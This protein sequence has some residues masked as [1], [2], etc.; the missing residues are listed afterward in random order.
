MKQINP[1]LEQMLRPMP[2]SDAFR[3]KIADEVWKGQQALY[4][5]GLLDRYCRWIPKPT[6]IPKAASPI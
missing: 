3:Q 4:E 5:A 6:E 1:D 2:V